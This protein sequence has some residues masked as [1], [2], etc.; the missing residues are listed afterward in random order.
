[1]R[2]SLKIYVGIIYSIAIVEFIIFYQ[3]FSISQL[4]IAVGFAFLI[5]MFNTDIL[6]DL[7]A[8]VNYFFALPFVIPAFIFL[9]P[10]YAMF[11][12]YLAAFLIHKRKIWYKKLFNA[13][14]LSISIGVTS[15]L[16]HE[17]Y[18]SLNDSSFLYS[19]TFFLAII[20]FTTYYKIS[21]SVLIYTV[22]A[23][24]K[25]KFD[26]HVYIG[27][28]NSTKAAF[29]TFFIGLIN[30]V[31]FYYTNLLGVAAFTFLI[32]FFRP[33]LQYRLVFD[34]ELSTFTN[35]VLHIIKQMDPITH[36]HS[37]RVEFWT[38]MLAEKKGLPSTEIRQLSQ[39]ASWHDIGKIE[40]PFN[41]INKPARL[42]EDEYE[43]IK[44]H[45]EKGYQLVKDMGF[46]KKF[47][48]VIRHH[49]ER[50]DG[51]GYPSGL[52]DEKIPLHAR[53]MAI[54]DAFD[55]MTSD[56]SY[57]KALSMKEAVDEL[58]KFSGTQFD[59]ELVGIFIKALQEEYGYNYEGF[60]K[61]IIMNI[62]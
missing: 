48:P 52:K 16:F 6:H 32:Y 59:P 41:I 55:A 21:N 43:A 38:V 13:S 53:I 60:D 4:F 51:K 50:Y 40:I 34:N 8:N 2:S 62:K 24:D 9:E 25:G 26:M 7:Q 28:L 46:F 36:S 11:F 61:A 39:A 27:L 30:A 33:A 15:Y 45:P 37:E 23:L 10:F 47:I 57:R 44:L 19:V 3:G 35:F 5:V 49:H 18:P 1:M 56:R 58:M 22:I 42:T 29:L 20:L 17:L 12:M 54:T 14:V 31:L